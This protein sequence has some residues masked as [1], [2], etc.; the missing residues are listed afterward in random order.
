MLHARPMLNA[1]PMLQP[2]RMC[3]CTGREGCLGAVAV[4]GRP[5]MV[6]TSL[7]LHDAPKGRD[8]RSAGGA[9]IGLRW[10]EANRALHRTSMS[11][12]P[13]DNGRRNP[14]QRVCPLYG[15]IFCTK[16]P[17]RRGCGAHL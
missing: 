16:R 15:Q 1:H 14:G 8:G 11:G 10:C 3:L 2:A 7:R 6:F 17:R 9:F 4:P 5:I 12:Q 13:P